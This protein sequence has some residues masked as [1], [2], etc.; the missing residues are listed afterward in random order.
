MSAARRVHEVRREQ[1]QI[2]W[3]TLTQDLS[4]FVTD[5]NHVRPVEQVER[6]ETA[7][8]VQ[9]PVVIVPDVTRHEVLLMS[10][11]DSRGDAPAWNGPSQSRNGSDSR[12]PKM[13][14]MNEAICGITSDY[15]DRPV[16]IYHSWVTVYRPADFARR[17]FLAEAVGW[18]S[19]WTAGDCSNAMTHTSRKPIFCG[20]RI[21]S[22]AASATT[23]RDWF[24]TKQRLNRAEESNRKLRE[25]NRR[26]KQ[27][28]KELTASL[29]TADDRPTRNRGEFD[30]FR[31]LR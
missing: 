18:L 17:A 28:N 22:S 9:P 24:F 29:K 27:Q 15:T 7:Q 12:L 30:E 1:F 26:L 3:A 5:Q 25:E 4:E 2:A 13:R 21:A 19:P 23:R 6:G 14:R 16:H 20:M 31:S 8:Y 10:P 11:H